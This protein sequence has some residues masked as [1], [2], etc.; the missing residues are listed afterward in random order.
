MIGV[1]GEGQLV[2]RQAE[3]SQYPGC[4]AH[5]PVNG[6]GKYGARRDAEPER[7]PTDCSPDDVGRAPDEAK[8][9]RTVVEAIIK[10]NQEWRSAL[11][12]ADA[13]P[14][15]SKREGDVMQPTN[16]IA[17]ILTAIR[18]RD[19]IDRRLMEADVIELPHRLLRTSQAGGR[20]VDTMQNTR[21]WRDR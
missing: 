4:A 11:Q 17:K 13:R 19:G 10:I 8:P 9:S 14:Q 3:P 1:T 7:H 21:A 16:G 18:Q 20:L 15:P 6:R 2:G 12:L 5:R